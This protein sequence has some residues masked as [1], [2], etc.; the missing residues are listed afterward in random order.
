MERLDIYEYANKNLLDYSG[1][2]STSNLIKEYAIYGLYNLLSA[3]D[4]IGGSVENTR[5]IAL[6][7]FTFSRNEHRWRDGYPYGSI[8]SMDTNN[9]PFMPLGFRP[10]CCGITMCKLSGGKINPNEILEKRE[11]LSTLFPDLSKDDLNRGNHFIGIYYDKENSEYYSII[12]GSF[13][14]V[15]FGYQSLPGLYT[16]KTKYWDNKKHTYRTPYTK[17]EYLIDDAAIEYYNAFKT[18]DKITKKNREKIAEFL[19]EGCNIIFNETHEG[20]F[21]E[22]TIILGAYVMNHPFSCPIMLSSETNL[23][24]V[25]INKIIS[26]L[27]FY[28]CPHG[29]GYYLTNMKDGHYNSQKSVYEIT[30]TNNAKL[31]TTD[32]RNLIYTYRTNTDN[33]WINTFN[34][35]RYT[36]RLQTIY[37]FKL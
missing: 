16:D 5:L 7:D 19:F 8:I 20:L 32:I 12:H 24:I 6:P 34:L 14:F 23:P 10:N 30:Y 17:F 28:A 2:D 26:D 9:I 27:G 29:G 4:E 22:H 3:I 1:Q 33:V 31:I 21:N 13:S 15:K 18:Y 37:N 36:K 11:R 35:G 25:E